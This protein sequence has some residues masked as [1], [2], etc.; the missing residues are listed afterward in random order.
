MK[1]NAKN[2][3]V[4][5]LYNLLT[6][7]FFKSSKKVSRLLVLFFTAVFLFESLGIRVMADESEEA[8]PYFEEMEKRRNA[9]VQS[10]EIEDWPVGPKVGADAAILMDAE[11]GQIL[12][13]KNIDNKEYPASTTKIMTCLLAMENLNIDEQ[14]KINQSAI[15]ANDSDGSNM[16]LYAGEMLTLDELLHGVLISSANEACNAIAEKISGNI[17]GF[18]ELMNKRAEALGLSNTHFMSANGLFNEE[19]YTTARDLATIGREFFSYDYLC[20]IA[21]TSMY[22]IH[23]SAGHR[24]HSLYSKNKLYKGREYAYEYLVGSKTGYT[25]EARQTLVSCAQKNGIKLIC[26][27]MKEESPYQ[28]SDTVAL[29]DYGFNSFEKIKVASN[30]KSFGFNNMEHF[31]QGKQLM[32]LSFPSISIDE[33]AYLLLPIGT[34]FSALS[35]ELSYEPAGNRY[36]ARIKYSFNNEELGSAGIRFVSEK[37]LIPEDKESRQKKNHGKILQA[38]TWK[39]VTS[40]PITGE[41][42]VIVNIKILALECSL[43]LCV[44]LLL[45]HFV[46]LFRRTVSDRRV[47]SSF[48]KKTE[49]PHKKRRA[50]LKSAG[51][52]KGKRR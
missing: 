13:A 40:N 43:T 1:K 5:N 41:K 21:S 35:K 38:L 16:G 30:E 39:T 37:N 22:E 17:E 47:E 24:A 48:R 19:H 29:F 27:V 10:N 44:L 31:D 49:S 2:T 52:I 28:F 51:R 45:I 15:D 7:R 26:V 9:R 32:G 46:L 11:T 33:A 18:V 3:V 42:Q 4:N 6:N 14:I 23:E 20:K 12:Y 50:A 25:G 8:N 36:F 34:E